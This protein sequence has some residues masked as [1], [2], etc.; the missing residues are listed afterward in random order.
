MATNVVKFQSEPQ[1]LMGKESDS[2]QDVL[3]YEE[4]QVTAESGDTSVEV[5]TELNG[6]HVVITPLNA[7]GAVAAPGFNTDFVLTDGAITFNFTDPVAD[8]TFNYMI[9]GKL[10]NE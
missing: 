3:Y 6:R 4:G 5:P 1:R 10:L 9:I 7:G 2:R 8:C